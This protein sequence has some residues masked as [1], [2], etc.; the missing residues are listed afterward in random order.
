MRSCLRA[1]LC[2]LWSLALLC[3]EPVLKPV[4]KAPFRYLTFIHPNKCR[5]STCPAGQSSVFLIDSFVQKRDMEAKVIHRVYERAVILL[6]SIKSSKSCCLDQAELKGLRASENM[7]HYLCLLAGIDP[8]KVL[9][10][11]TSSHTEQAPVVVDNCVWRAFLYRTGCPEPQEETGC[12]Q[13][14]GIQGFRGIF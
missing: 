5:K 9:L 2:L 7:R 3:Y 14:T 13:S 4:G 1:G 6:S 8:D 12:P 10:V 11:L